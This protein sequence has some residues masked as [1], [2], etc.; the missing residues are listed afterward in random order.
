MDGVL[1][2]GVTPQGSGLSGGHVVGRM[3]PPH[4]HQNVSVLSRACEAS[5]LW[6]RGIRVVGGISVACQLPLRWRS[7]PGASGGPAVV[8]AAI[9]GVGDGACGSV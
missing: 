8:P 6:Q 2:V 1:G 5:V 9:K 7:C 4:P 3:I